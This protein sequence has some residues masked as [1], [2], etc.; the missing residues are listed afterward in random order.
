MERR[1]LVSDSVVGRQD[2]ILCVGQ[3]ILMYT[4]HEANAK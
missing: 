4:A 1:G 2:N 3:A